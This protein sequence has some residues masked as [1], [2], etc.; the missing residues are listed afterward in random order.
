MITNKTP[1]I[2]PKG[3]EPQ[4]PQAQRKTLQ[5]LKNADCRWPIGDP[6]SQ[7]FY[8]CGGR[9][10]GTHPYCQMHMRRAFQPSRPRDYRSYAPRA[11]A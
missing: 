11:A 2:L 7:D 4:I 9:T 3:Q 8:F 5:A 10:D 1:P 6:Q